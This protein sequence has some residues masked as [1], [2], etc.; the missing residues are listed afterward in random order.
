MEYKFVADTMLEKLARWLRIIGCDVVFDSRME[1]KELIN[2]ANIQ[3][4]VFIT[5]RRYMPEDIEI[6][7]L[8]KL[9]SEDFEEQFRDIVETFRLDYQDKIFTRCTRCNQEVVKVS[10]D[11]VKDRVPAMSWSGF[12]DFYECP[13]CKKVFWKGAHFNNT[14]KKLEKIMR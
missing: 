11:S 5:R 14:I 8:H 3:S 6:K 7:K 1:L 12:N 2:I 9:L 10:K 13:S 4:R